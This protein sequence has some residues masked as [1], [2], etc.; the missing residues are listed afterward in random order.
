[1]AVILRKKIMNNKPVVTFLSIASLAMIFAS[2]T[3]DAADADESIFTY[4]YVEGA[5]EYYG[6]DDNDST[7]QRL[8]GSYEVNSEYNVLAEYAVGEDI[9]S[10]IKFD[11]VSL[12]AAYHKEVADKTDLTTNL[13]LVYQDFDEG[14]SDTRLAAGVGVRH[15]LMDEVEVSADL[16]YND[17]ARFKVGIRYYVSDELSA[18][19]GFSASSGEEIAYFNL[20]WGF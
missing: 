17:G 2:A 9:D 20:R 13:K 5:F 10:D 8:T 12:G 1:M 6:N 3:V 15:Q 11:E 14:S 16:D 19:A 4:N 18:G 7:I